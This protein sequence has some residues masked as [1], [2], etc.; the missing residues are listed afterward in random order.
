MAPTRKKAYLTRLQQHTSANTTAEQLQD[1]ASCQSCRCADA[2]EQ[3]Q[4]LSC[5]G[6]TGCTFGGRAAQRGAGGRPAR[7]MAPAVSRFMT[8]ASRC[9]SRAACSAASAARLSCTSATP[10]AQPRARVEEYA[11]SCPEGGRPK[12]AA[13][14]AKDQA[15]LQRSTGP[16]RAGPPTASLRSKAARLAGVASTAWRDGTRWLRAYP[17]LTRTSLPSGPRLTLSCA[18]TAQHGG[19]VGT[20]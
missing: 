4:L 1:L 9:S 10:C 14:T 2:V 6:A 16:G 7:T 3:T 18:P 20:A 12:P 8:S 13:R 5:P 17:G 19:N 15:K 11:A